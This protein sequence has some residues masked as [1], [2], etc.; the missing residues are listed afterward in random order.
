MQTNQAKLEASGLTAKSKYSRRSPSPPPKN[1][2]LKFL[3]HS[4]HFSIEGPFRNTPSTLGS[5]FLSRNC[6]SI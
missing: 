1:T 4:H 2:I 3:N 6:D 5:S